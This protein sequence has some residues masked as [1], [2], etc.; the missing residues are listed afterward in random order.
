MDVAVEDNVVEKKESKFDEDFVKLASDSEK[1]DSDAEDEEF[2]EISWFRFTDVVKDDVDRALEAEG[3]KAEDEPEDEQAF[4]MESLFGNKEKLLENLKEQSG[5]SESQRESTK[6]KHAWEDSDDE[7]VTIKQGLEKTHKKS[8]LLDPGA[9]YKKYLSKKYQKIV[10]EPKWAD[11]DRV[12]SDSDDDELLKTAG[13]V[14]KGKRGALGE[15]TIGFKRLEDLNKSTYCEGLVTSVEFHPTSS[16]ALVTGLRG[17]ASIY[18]IEKTKCDKLHSIQFKKFPLRCARLSLDGSE[19]ILGSKTSCFFTYNLITGQ[20]QKHF[21]PKGMTKMRNFEISPNG[22]F[23]AVAGRF[24]EIHL[25]T[26]TTK[27]WIC[28]LKQEHDVAAMAFSPDSR[29]LFVH[30]RDSEVSV[31]DL[32]AQKMMHRFMDDG[33]V[34]GSSIATSPS[35]K[36]L[37]TGSGQ[38]IVNVYDAENVLLSKMPTPTKI[39]KNLVTSI[40]STTFNPSSELLAMCSSEANDALKLAQFPSAK[41]FSNFPGNNLTKAKPNVLRFS[42]GGRYLAVGNLNGRVSLYLLKHYEEF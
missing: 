20:Q 29:K 26:V 17:I 38:G 32:T 11:M 36:F 18:S 10:G 30:S 25:L 37:A 16:V 28:T 27:E 3:A 42:P 34:S 2:P 35:G 1:N 14:L 22:E 39:F 4:L 7:E 23:L 33:C 6:R 21:L 41:V 9:E 31:F 8:L 19:A 40:S 12:E 15:N 24:G 13:H 5:E